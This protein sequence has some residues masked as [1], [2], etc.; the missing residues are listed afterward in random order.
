MNLSIILKTLESEC[1]TRI[2]IEALHP[3]FADVEDLQMTPEQPLHHSHFCRGKK[4]ADNN[5]RCSMNKRRSLEIAAL[6]R[7]FCGK[8]PFG[9]RELAVPVMFQNR[10][11]AV[12]YFTLLPGTV[13]LTEL[14]AKGK[15]LAEYIRLAIAAAGG[16][17]KNPRRNTPEY[18][19]S[20]ILFFFDLHYMENISEADLAEYLGLN[21]TYFSSLFKRITGKN[22]R[23]MLNERRLHEAKIYLRLHTDLR[24]ADIARMCGYA[25]S[26]YFSALFHRATGHSP[27]SYRLAFSEK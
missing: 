22:F 23:Q 27:K 1:C 4:L 20:R 24:I 21:V 11:A 26:N 13:T 25:D 6:G 16:E 9:V 3:A 18:Y 15:W 17:E 19:R 12:C 8:C 10:L 5:R 7:S 14:R 2:S